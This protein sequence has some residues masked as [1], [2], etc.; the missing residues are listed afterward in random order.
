MLA[1]LISSQRVHTSIVNGFSC[2]CV[3][4]PSVIQNEFFVI[5]LFAGLLGFRD[6]VFC[7]VFK[8]PKQVASHVEMSRF[9]SKSC[10]TRSPVEVNFLVIGP[11]LSP[12]ETLY[13]TV[14]RLS[15]ND[16]LYLK[17]LDHKNGD[18]C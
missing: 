2:V 17:P 14:E 5:R 1:C 11:T 3:D 8:K 6:W 15:G 7:L 18:P 9:P 10:R 13:A 4:L 12:T 16:I